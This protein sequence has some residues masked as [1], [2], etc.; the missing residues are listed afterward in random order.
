MDWFDLKDDDKFTV[1]GRCL[2][3]VGSAYWEEVLSEV[4]GSTNDDFVH[5][6]TL[7]VE[8]VAGVQNLQDAILRWISKWKKPC[9]LTLKEYVRR[10]DELYAYAAGPYTRGSM[11]IPT[12]ALKKET[13]FF[14]M[15]K[16]HQEDFAQQYQDVND[17]TIQQMI[18]YFEGC[19]RKYTSSGKTAQIMAAHE[20]KCRKANAKRRNGHRSLN[21]GQGRGR[22]RRDDDRCRY[23]D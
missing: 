18:T 23:D 19:F 21:Q 10:C 5:A 7:Y 8:K 1:F 13:F 22:G 4:D 20:D 9:V 2:F 14:D 15:C 6:L 12:D 16:S 3:G 11:E 17:V